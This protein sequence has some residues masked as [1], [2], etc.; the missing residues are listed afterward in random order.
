[1][2]IRYLLFSLLLLFPA[3]CSSQ[4]TDTDYVR[5]AYGM[6]LFDLTEEDSLYYT[7]ITTRGERLKV[8]RFGVEFR[9][10]RDSLY[11]YVMSAYYK[12]VNDNSDYSQTILFDIL[13]DKELQIKEIRQLP[14]KFMYKEE[15]NHKLFTSILKSTSGKWYKLVEGD[16][17]YLYAFVIR[18]Y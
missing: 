6:P 7:Y 18:H 2:I 1:M 13:F 17:W 8:R 4:E 11:D 16:N 15:R 9:G 5:D 14:R 10:G 3:I 12:Q